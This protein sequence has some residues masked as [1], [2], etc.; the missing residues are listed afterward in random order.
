M[1]CDLGDRLEI[2]CFGYAD[3]VDAAAVAQQFDRH[4]CSAWSC[5][6]DPASRWSPITVPGP[7]ILR[8]DRIPGTKPQQAVLQ[9]ITGGYRRSIFS[10]SIEEQFRRFIHHRALW[11]A[12]LPWPP[13]DPE[14]WWSADPKQQARNRG[15]YHGLRR[16]SLHVINEL[17]GKALEG[18]ADPDALRAARRFYFGYREDIYRAACR[19]RR[20]LQLTSTFPL[21]A[22]VIYSGRLYLIRSRR[23]TDGSYDA[24]KRAI[25]DADARQQAA[26][27]LVERGA[28]LRDVA[29]VLGVP[30]TLRRIKPGTVHY[31]RSIFCQYPDWLTFMPD[32]VPR[33][34]VWMAAVL[35]AQEN[36]G[37]DFAAW[38]ARH[39]PEI[40]GRLQ[41]VGWFLSD[42]SDWARAPG[43]PGGQF[44]TRPFVPTMSLKTVT[45]LSA[46]WHEAVAAN[47]TG[48]D[49]TF[50]T[51]WYPA[52]KVSGY[53]I[54]P[55]DNSAALHR[56][57]AAM[58]H[59][60]GTYADRVRSGDLQ[61]YS[62]RRDGQRLATF[63]LVRMAESAAL[64]EIRGPCNVQPPKAVTAAVRRWLRAQ[65]PL[66]PVTHPE[67]P[68]LDLPFDCVIQPSAQ[69]H[70]AVDHRPV[71]EEDLKFA[72][73]QGHEARRA[74]VKQR[75]VP[76]EYRD[77]SRVREVVEWIRGWQEANELR[78]R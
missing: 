62:V 13:E 54:L 53:D 77:P 29:A 70:R 51:A 75:A 34:K 63:S 22:A 3:A 56:E 72:R 43:T 55:I 64:A 36:G 46:Q 28:P 20:A 39:A 17:I 18:A 76:P 47:M 31:A 25:K 58:H 61:V 26:A 10:R 60:I 12:G 57:G 33:A 32:T 1:K 37:E 35:C 41:Q 9:R 48:P 45:M 4:R 6:L 38:A 40:P 2:K 71:A 68:N 73:Q 21:L 30:M 7:L 19:S 27:D 67:P 52:I 50:P 59:C 74:G 8:P 44:V 66:P 49:V 69:D 5:G 23:S 42:I 15:I 65:A 16:Q 14:R 78:A 11:R 24:F